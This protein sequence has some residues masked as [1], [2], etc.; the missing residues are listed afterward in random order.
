MINVADEMGNL[1]DCRIPGGWG[2]MLREATIINAI[3]VLLLLFF[4]P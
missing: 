3:V 2:L 4:P 1:V